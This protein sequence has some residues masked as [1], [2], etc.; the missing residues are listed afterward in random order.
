MA[1]FVLFRFALSWPSVFRLL[2]FLFTSVFLFILLHL[3][4]SRRLIYFIF[5]V[6]GLLY[7]TSLLSVMVLN[8]VFYYTY[9]FPSLFLF[10]EFDLLVFLTSTDLVVSF[11]MGCYIWLSLYICHGYVFCLLKDSY[12][13][14]PWRQSNLFNANIFSSICVTLSNS[15]Y[16]WSLRFSYFSC[17]V[18]CPFPLFFFPRCLIF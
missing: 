1:Y 9:R 6:Y 16:F 2:D 8:C 13:W 5:V 10:I 18:C 14:F 11:F 3:Y 7:L 4:F 17:T 15:L 12:R